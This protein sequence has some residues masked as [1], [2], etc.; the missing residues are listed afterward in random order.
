MNTIQPLKQNWHI[1][2][3]ECGVS[4]RDQIRERVNTESNVEWCKGFALTEEEHWASKVNWFPRATALIKECEEYL[5]KLT[6]QNE[7]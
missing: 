1:Q 2:E 4:V 5:T 6:K 7:I 3:E